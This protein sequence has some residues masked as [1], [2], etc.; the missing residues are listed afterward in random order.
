VEAFKTFLAYAGRYEIAGDKI[1]H[2]I[3]I[4]SIQNYVGRNLV[5]TIRIDGE[6]LILTTPPTPVNGKVQTVELIWESLTPSL[7]SGA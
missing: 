4:S 6:R 1:T 3:E 5:R 2:R 7:S